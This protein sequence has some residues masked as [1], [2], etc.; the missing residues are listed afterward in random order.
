M[1]QARI[2]LGGVHAW[3]ELLRTGE[4]NWRVTADLY[5]SLTADF[6]AYLD[7]DEVADFAAR[8]RS[9][10]RAPTGARFSARVTPGRNN[11]LTLDAEPVEDGFAFFVFL[12]PNGDDT[13]CHLQMELDPVDA[14]ELGDLFAAL[15]G[16]LAR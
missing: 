3:V 1:E 4:G 9:G 11:P 12:T 6:P 15:Q 13:V 14:A 5:S 16:S 10:L 2:R 7:D 8:M